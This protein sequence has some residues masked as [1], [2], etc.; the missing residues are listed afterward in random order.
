[1][2]Q[3]ADSALVAA[4]AAGGNQAYVY[5]ED[6]PDIA[7]R[8]ESVHWEVQVD[9][10]LENGRLKLRCQTIVPVRPDSGIAPHYEVLLG[11]HSG[12][13][14]P[15]PIA[16]FIE[17]AERYNRMRAVDRWPVRRIPLCTTVASMGCARIKRG[18]LRGS[19]TLL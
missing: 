5:R 17:A 15:L 13:D 3:A 10:A 18:G 6:D 4:K 11:V 9:D 19:S 8:K 12:A 14:K 7:R 1:M 2:L 16:E